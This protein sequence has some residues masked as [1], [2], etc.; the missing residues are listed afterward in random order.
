MPCPRTCIIKLF[1]PAIIPLRSKL[2]YL[3]KPVKVPDN[4]NDT[5]LLR[6]GIHYSH[7][8]SDFHK[9]SYDKLTLIL[10]VGVS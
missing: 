6:Y 4:N 2:V 9:T 3:Y 5:S 7:E 8:R 1:T 10:K